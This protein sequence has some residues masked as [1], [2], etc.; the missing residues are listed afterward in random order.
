MCAS[1]TPLKD[2]LQSQQDYLSW[3]EAHNT[4]ILIMYTF[5]PFIQLGQLIKTIQESLSQLHNFSPNSAKVWRQI[6]H[7]T[8]PKL[9]LYDCWN[10]FIPL[11]NRH[12]HIFKKSYFQNKPFLLIVMTST[13]SWKDTP[14]FAILRILKKQYYLSLCTFVSQWI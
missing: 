6:S 10:T 12:P 7:I 5:T 11:S 8:V 4:D 3:E 13:T 14:A 9:P 2:K 1:P